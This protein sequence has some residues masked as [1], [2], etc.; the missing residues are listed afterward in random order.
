VETNL[1]DWASLAEII[2]AVAVTV[3]LL[4]VGVEVRRNT[5][6]TQASTLQDSVG[7]DVQILSAVGA[8]SEASMALW[9]Y[10]FQTDSVSGEQ[11]VQG[12]W[13]F[14]SAVRHWENIYLQHTAGTL[15]EDAWNARE[16]AL[17][18]LVTCPGWDEFM[19]SGLGGMMGG[20]FL[21]FAREIR[22]AAGT[23]TG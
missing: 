22:A 13:L 8:T 15:S 5:I 10:T 11:L 18:V 17:R 23:D 6:A 3:S 12:R 19:E 20:P 14:A 9:Q 2:G 4:F 21:E 7:Y 1:S 16:P